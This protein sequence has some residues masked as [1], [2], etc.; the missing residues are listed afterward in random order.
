[1][2]PY[3]RHLIEEAARAAAGLRWHVPETII[4]QPV[5]AVFPSSEVAAVSAFAIALLVLM[6]ARIGRS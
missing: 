5:P 3:W 4:G 2:V 6:F 1:M